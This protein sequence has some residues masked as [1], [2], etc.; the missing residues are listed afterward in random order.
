MAVIHKDCT[1]IGREGRWRGKGEESA[2]GGGGGGRRLAEDA[3][4]KIVKVQ[5]SRT[6]VKMFLILVHTNLKP[7]EKQN[8]QTNTNKTRKKYIK[9]KEKKKRKK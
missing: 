2:G 9:L 5:L 7:E 8:K 1:S 6:I 3:R 4:E